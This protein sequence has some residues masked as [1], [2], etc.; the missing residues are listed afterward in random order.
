MNS[1]LI[2][3]PKRDEFGQL[4]PQHLGVSDV[5]AQNTAYKRPGVNQ[6]ETKTY[7][8]ELEKQA[9]ERRVM[10]D[11]ESQRENTDYKSHIQPQGPLSS[12]VLSTIHDYRKKK[13]EWEGHNP[14]A[15]KF[16]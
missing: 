5:V 12:P 7:L 13:F 11:R 10:R 9:S 14:N 8:T 16:R 1:G 4:L 3:R 2:G 15:I 6:Q